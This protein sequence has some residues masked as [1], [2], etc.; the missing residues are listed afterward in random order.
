MTVKRKLGSNSSLMLHH[1]CLFNGNQVGAGD[2]Q[3]G[4]VSDPVLLFSLKLILFLEQL[5]ENLLLR[6]CG[7]CD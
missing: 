3:L 6:R 5:G 1:I 7:L 4:Q 2:E